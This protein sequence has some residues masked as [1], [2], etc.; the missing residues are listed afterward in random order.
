METVRRMFKYWG[1]YEYFKTNI[2]SLDIN[3]LLVS[4]VRRDFCKIFYELLERAFYQVGIWVKKIS[5]GTEGK[6]KSVGFTVYIDYK[7]KK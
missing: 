6:L 2:G 5:L 1:K 3:D 7:G 4:L